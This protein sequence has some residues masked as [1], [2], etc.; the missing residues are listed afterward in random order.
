MSMFDSPAWLMRHIG[1]PDIVDGQPAEN[2]V[3][4]SIERL[5]EKIRKYARHLGADLIKI[6]KL[7][8][9]FVYSHR[10]RKIYENDPYGSPIELQHRYAISLG[11]KEDVDL[12]RTAPYPSEMIETGRVY[13]LSAIVSVVLAQYIRM[14][15]YPARA[16]HFRNYQILPV[17][18]AVDAGM[19]ELGRCGFLITKEFGNCLRLST[20]TTDMPLE[21]DSPIDIG[22]QDFCN[23]C[24]LCADVC[25]SGAISAGEK[26]MVRGFEK[27]QIDDVKC[28]TYWNKV[29]TDCGMC[30]GSCPWSL[31]PDKWWHKIST[32]MATRS[33]LARVV[34]LRLY[35]LLFGRYKPHRSPD[36]FEP[37]GNQ[38]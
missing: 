24:K 12:V 38:V 19:G 16:H 1:E 3:E 8:Q 28:L 11:F 23:M 2:R 15:G 13:L 10:G 9:A 34:L 36:W 32:K 31:P 7:D 33:H 14:L 26:V 21:C 4:L 30:I 6:G 5:T 22:V 27:W 17:P 35:P 37:R 25:P 18:V 20:V 29:G